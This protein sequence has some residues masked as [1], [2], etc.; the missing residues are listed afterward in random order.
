MDR[1]SFL[2]RLASGSALVFALPSVPVEYFVLDRRAEKIRLIERLMANALAEHH[3][4]FEQALAA[5]D[6]AFARLLQ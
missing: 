4:L 1:R 2:T 3:R 6:E 5:H